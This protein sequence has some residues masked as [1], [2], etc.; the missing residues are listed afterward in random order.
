MQERRR[1]VGARRITLE[2]GSLGVQF[3]GEQMDIVMLSM[4]KQHRDRLLDERF[5]VGSA[6][7]AAWGNGKS[8]HED[9]TA[10]Y[11]F[12][13]LTKGAFAGFGLDGTALKADHS[14]NKVLSTGSPSRTMMS[15]RATRQRRTGRRG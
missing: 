10:K 15:L 7:S 6:A 1:L 9:P 11:V 5:V 14:G 4:D 13:G 12:Y 8:A 2:G 3:G